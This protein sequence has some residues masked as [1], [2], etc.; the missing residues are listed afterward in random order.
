MENVGAPTQI[1]LDARMIRSSNNLYRLSK[2]SWDI[3][4][5][6]SEFIKE[7]KILFDIQTQ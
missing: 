3:N 4:G 2:V 7:N 1:T 5:D 6:G